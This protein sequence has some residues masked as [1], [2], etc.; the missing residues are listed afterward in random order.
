MAGRHR[1]AA[2]RCHGFAQ[3]IKYR[4][5]AQNWEW[6]AKVIDDPKTA[7]AWCMAGGKMAIYTGLI[8]Q[9]KPS[10]LEWP[11]GCFSR[12]HFECGRLRSLVDVLRPKFSVGLPV[13]RIPSIPRLRKFP[14]NLRR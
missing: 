5:E 13:I 7:D 4:P 1:P 10:D 11:R 2:L 14:L 3:A 12:T 6:S 9:I 8:R